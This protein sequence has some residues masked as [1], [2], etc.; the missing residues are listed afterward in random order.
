MSNWT[1][2]FIGVAI[3]SQIIMF[4][5]LYLCKVGNTF[6]ITS[7]DWFSLAL[8]SVNTVLY[9]FVSITSYHNDV[10]RGYN[11]RIS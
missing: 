8:S 11:V 1:K 4:I 2:G 3:A 6:Y 5:V 10:S 9:I 7:T